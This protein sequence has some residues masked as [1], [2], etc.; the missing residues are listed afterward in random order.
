MVLIDADGGNT[1]TVVV[2]LGGLASVLR[3][4]LRYENVVAKIPV[5]LGAHI[6][7]VVGAGAGRAGALVYQLA[8]EYDA[9][10]FQMLRERSPAAVIAVDRLRGRLNEWV[11]DTPTV[12]KSLSE[13][14]RGLI[15]DLKLMEANGSSAPERGIEVA[16][17][18]SMVHGDLHGANVLVTPQGEPTLIDYG[19]VRRANAALDP[20]TLELSIVFHPAM[21]GGLGAWPTEQQCAGWSDLDAYC[22]GCP[23]EDF[24][25]ACRAWARDVAAGDPEI[26]A[27]AYAY[28][29]RQT[30]YRES[31]RPLA[32]ALAGAALPQIMAG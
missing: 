31:T 10:L 15:S 16:V 3:E 20:V 6:L 24:V 25:R 7:Y 17:R 32:D 26:L 9:S 28:A 27:S 18:Q 5:G 21:A 2:K 12:V 23:V 29:T 1:G 19:E 30:K 4:A 22:L 14:R 8:D 13:M 11:R